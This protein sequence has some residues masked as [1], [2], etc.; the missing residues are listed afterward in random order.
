MLKRFTPLALMFATLGFFS[1]QTVFACDA[2]ESEIIVNIDSP[3]GSINWTVTD[4]DGAELGSGNEDGGTVCI[5]ED[6]PIYFNIDGYMYLGDQ[7]Q[8]FYDGVLIVELNGY[9]LYGDDL[10]FPINF[11]EGQNCYEAVL[12][13]EGSF[14]A[15]NPNYWY[16]FTPA[17]TGS[18]R[19]TTCDL[20]NTC[21]TK[22]WIYNHCEGLV[23]TEFAEG[24]YS[25]NDDACGELAE[26]NVIL[27]GGDT[28]YIRV[29]DVLDF[30]EGTAINWTLSYEGEPTGCTDL[31]ACNYD[32][33]AMDD[34]GSCLYPGNPDCPNGPDLVLEE[35]TFDG[36]VGGWGADFTLE[37]VDADD[38]YGSCYLSEGALLGSGM[39]D[40]LKFGIQ[41][42]NYGDEDYHIGSVG[43]SPY[44]VYDPC[45]GHYH[46]VDYGEYLLYDSLGNEIPAGH[47]N[48]YAV[49]DLCGIGG[50]YGG[51]DMGI[52][53]GCYDA[54]SKGTGGQW[55]DIT[56]VPDGTYTL[57]AR[58]N[59]ENHPDID[60]R[61]E[62]NLAN[63]WLSTC[64]KITHSL[65]GDLVAE[66][67]DSC[68]TYLDC[69]GEVFGNATYD[70]DGNCMGWHHVGDL[71]SDS[72][73]TY[74][75]VDLYATNI[76]DNTI[77][78]QVCNDANAD[79]DIDVVDAALVM[80]C[81][82]QSL[83]YVH[84]TD[85]CDLPMNL[86]SMFDTVTLSI[87]NVNPAMHYLDIYSENPTAKILGLQFAMEGITI[88]S[89]VNLAAETDGSDFRIT[90]SADEI[91]AL[92]YSE[93]AIAVRAEPIP[94]LRIYYTAALP[95][96]VCIKH[97]TAAVNDAFKEVNVAMENNCVTIEETGVTYSTVDP[98]HIS[99]QPNPFS[100][101]TNIIFSNPNHHDCIFE[102]VNLNGAVIRT[103][104]TTDEQILIERNDLP[105]GVYMYRLTGYNNSQK[106]KIVIQ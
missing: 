35:L 41:I 96:D 10:S 52:S 39:R 65:A 85:L 86:V 47:K 5:P 53:A 93:V 83:G 73:R 74:D 23:P 58:V 48:G 80:G 49:M 24:T 28:Y 57:V 99:V 89:V 27:V 26:I 102:L 33:L 15:P 71:N 78:A 4:A 88:D 11:A 81:S 103:I 90:Y 66:I 3:W 45:H 64:L 44:L 75:D 62:T 20:G 37:Q 43:D 40:V 12:I 61:V 84:A 101:S 2:G 50:G 30:C 32:P 7:T 68:S 97:F 36:E 13:T 19:L 104:S 29:G 79:S 70:C 31:F 106:G 9:D 42:W 56:D 60:G 59:W 92:G 46:Y 8:V 63:N 72:T 51:G 94:I 38:D 105:A 34:D 18:Y 16:E 55:V 100:E 54:Y 67:V 69:L 87:G 82:N 76:L 1:S 95:A 14:T 25:Y 91:I 22:L 98:F 77:I 17:S 21:N 6:I